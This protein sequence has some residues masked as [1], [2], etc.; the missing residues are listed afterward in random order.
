VGTVKI[1]YR[2]GTIS[3]QAAVHPN[4]TLGALNM[5][6]ERRSFVTLKPSLRTLNN[7]TTLGHVNKK[8]V[9]CRSIHA[10]VIPEVTIII[11]F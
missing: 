1:L 8:L 7:E 5:K 2:V 11:K 4:C 9:L 10:H 6:E 3:L